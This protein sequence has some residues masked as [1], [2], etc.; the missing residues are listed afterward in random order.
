MKPIVVRFPPSAKLGE[1]AEKEDAILFP[2]LRERLV[3][4]VNE[5]AQ[6]GYTVSNNLRGRL[7]V[8]KASRARN[9]FNKIRRG[10]K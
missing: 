2:R 10:V 5:W 3:D 1:P 7:V 9:L 4:V 6:R 8:K